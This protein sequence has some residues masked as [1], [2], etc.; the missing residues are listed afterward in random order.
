M[1]EGRLGSDR[2]DRSERTLFPDRQ[3]RDGEHEEERICPSIFHFSRWLG[4]F[5]DRLRVR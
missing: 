5:S 1:R 2:T 3:E 4:L